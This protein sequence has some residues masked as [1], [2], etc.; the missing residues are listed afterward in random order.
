[1]LAIEVNEGL[2][3]MVNTY[4]SSPICYNR[5]RI[6]FFIEIIYLFIASVVHFFKS[7]MKDELL[8]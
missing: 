8:L 7:D 1:M 6:Y 5:L 2:L 3:L 4:H